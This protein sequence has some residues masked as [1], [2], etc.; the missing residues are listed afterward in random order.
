MEGHSS[1]AKEVQAGRVVTNGV[2]TSRSVDAKR[3]ALAGAA[4]G[5]KKRC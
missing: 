5:E 4:A 2:R 3:Q 1:G